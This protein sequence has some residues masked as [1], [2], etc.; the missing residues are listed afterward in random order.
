MAVHVSF[1]M[2]C[3]TCEWF[4]PQHFEVEVLI[5]YPAGDLRWSIWKMAKATDSQSTNGSSASVDWPPEMDGSPWIRGSCGWFFSPK[6]SLQLRFIDCQAVVN[7]LWVHFENLLVCHTPLFEH[8]NY[9]RRS[10][11]WLSEDIR[12]IR[13]TPNWIITADPILNQG[14]TCIATCR[15]IWRKVNSHSK[16]LL[17]L[18]IANY[19]F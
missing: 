13:G 15:Q 2:H 9:T 16:N 1:G 19:C 18:D 5:P 6:S 8:L 4:Q 3:E 7:M 17:F 12:A 14:C 10:E 11:L